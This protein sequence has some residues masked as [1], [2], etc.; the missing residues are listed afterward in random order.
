MRTALTTLVLAMALSVAAQ[1][2]VALNAA[3]MEKDFDLLRRSL[4]EVHGGLYRFADKQ[5]TD[6]RFDGYR[7]KIA[8]MTIRRE[9][10]HLVMEVLADTRDG[11]MRLVM[12]DQIMSEFSK[13]RLLPFA[14]SIEDDRTIVRFNE[15]KDDSTIRP[16]YEIL[17]IN[18]EKT[19]AL[20]QRMYALLP[21]DGYI[22]TGKQARLEDSFAAYY[23]LL[24]DTTDH[25]SLTVKDLK[26]KVSDKRIMGVLRTEMEQNQQSNP[27]NA[28]I[29]NALR[30]LSGPEEN[31]SLQFPQPGTA[32]LRIRSFQGDRFYQQIDSVFNIIHDKK[33]SHLVLD[34]RG[35]GGGTDMYGAY[36][37]SQFVMKPFRY[38]D[39]IHLR[40]INP[41]F[42]HFREQSLQ[43]LREGTIVDPAGGFLAT[44]KL[45]PGVGE[46][47]PA[48]HPFTG[49]AFVLTDGGTF[50][51][52]ADVAALLR[53]LTKAVFI[54]EET[55]GGFEGNTSGS[56]AELLL[57]NSQLRVRMHLYEYWNAVKVRERG[58]GTLP[59]HVVA[60]RV[61]DQ[62]KGIDRVLGMAL[63]LAGK[64]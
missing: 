12:D 48:T 25:F 57:P 35:N 50:S 13:A 33:I 11:H 10:I 45:H 47:Q 51:T 3:G 28:T 42:T 5:T 29:V 38:F 32:Y 26:G 46:Q 16:G 31:I 27:V 56:N 22:L 15:T 14:L 54:G 23:W 64:E 53:Q 37:V 40:S 58:R 43:E 62:L 4:E 52:A 36:L 20:L 2:P 24:I 63:G 9:F 44:T 19:S 18:G 41:S 61:V 34:L 30:S 8:S 55:G 49:K 21:G 1:Q 17:A 59:D 39:R 6:A 7:Q 60:E